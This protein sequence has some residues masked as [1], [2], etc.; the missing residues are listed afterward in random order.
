MATKK[1]SL[2]LDEE[3]LAEARRR[4]GRRGLSGYVND[5]LRRRLQRDRLD[6]FVDE[7]EV[8]AGPIPEALLEEVRQAWP[9]P[10]DRRGP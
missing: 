2:V 6:A 9:A 10:G 3:L 8:E 5:A 4:V 1:V 7:L